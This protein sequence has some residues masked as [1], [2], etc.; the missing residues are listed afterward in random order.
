MDALKCRGDLTGAGVPIINSSIPV[1]CNK[2][3][4]MFLFLWRSEK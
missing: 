2:G 1:V 4:E 3:E